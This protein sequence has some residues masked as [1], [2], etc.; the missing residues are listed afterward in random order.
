[1]T[2]FYTRFQGFKLAWQEGEAGERC[3]KFQIWFF[4]SVV[5]SDNIKIRNVK[6]DTSFPDIYKK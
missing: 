6:N 4:F 3:N 5:F 2:A 1:M